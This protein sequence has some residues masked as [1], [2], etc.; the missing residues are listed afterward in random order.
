M[1]QYVSACFSQSSANRPKH[2]RYRQQH[3]CHVANMV[4]N[5]LKSSWYMRLLSN[6]VYIACFKSFLFKTDGYGRNNKF[7]SHDNI[8]QVE[9]CV[10]D[11]LKF[12]HKSK[13]KRRV[14][15]RFKHKWCHQKFQIMEGRC[16]NFCWWVVCARTHMGVV[17]V[18]GRRACLVG[19]KM[20]AKCKTFC[21]F[22][23]YTCL[24]KFAKCKMQKL[25]QLFFSYLQLLQLNLWSY[26]SHFY[27]HIFPL[28][29]A[30]VNFV[31]M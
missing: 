28:A 26:K 25:L 6:R 13:G 22:T 4:R 12:T 14:G 30:T 3:G 7:P 17:V 27:T 1:F 21:N 10:M 20:F 5:K 18:L 2:R 29:V 9:I 11:R 23:I 8:K 31:V 16:V 19:C 24:V 15:P